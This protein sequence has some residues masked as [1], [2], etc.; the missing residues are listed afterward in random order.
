MASKPQL[1][2][3][4]DAGS[5]ATRCAIC[6]FEDSRLKF[7]GHG[8]IDS[9]GWNKGRIADSQALTTCIQAAVQEAE[10]EAQ[11]SVEGMVVGLGGSGIEGCN[12]RGVYEFGRPHE[13]T[14]EDTA[15][16][17][18]RTSRVRLEEDR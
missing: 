7:L 1:A 18:E 11:V 4:L 9:I 3:G 2:V 15:Y 8:E 10:A 6:L 13:V 14:V 17:V 12:S 5:A 16:A